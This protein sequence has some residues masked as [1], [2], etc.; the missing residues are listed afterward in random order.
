MEAGVVVQNVGTALAI[1]EAVV[2]ARPLVER[3]VTITGAAVGRPCNLRA[4][5]GTLCTE[6]I[7]QAGG[8]SDLVGRV[9]MG[10]PMMGLALPTTDVPFMKSTS[11]LVL[12]RRDEIIEYELDPCIRCARCETH[13]PAG[14]A[15]ARIGLGVELDRIEVAERLHVLEC[16]ECGCCSYVCPARRPMTQL[17]RV[18]K[19][20]VLAQRA[21]RRAHG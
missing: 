15:T 20:A 6:L 14:L 3:A 12:M 21:R 2:A 9:V 16:M 1:Y 4:R 10:G 8:A 18:G 11:G 5:I 17:M 13:C 7:E 19:N